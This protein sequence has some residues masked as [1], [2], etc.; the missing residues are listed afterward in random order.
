M[1]RR[2]RLKK[3]NIFH[4]RFIPNSFK[5]II[6]VWEELASARNKAIK[7]V[8]RLPTKTAEARSI[9]VYK[10]EETGRTV[11]PSQTPHAQPCQSCFSVCLSH[12]PALPQLPPDVLADAEVP[13]A[14]LQNRYRPVQLSVTL[15]I[16]GWLNT[17]C[18]KALKDLLNFILTTTGSIFTCKTNLLIQQI[19]AQL[20]KHWTHSK[21]A[22]CEW[23]S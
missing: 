12:L 23:F 3:R 22:V 9:A 21:M 14:H 2:Q 10:Q 19:K 17:L 8:H 18:L 15:M 16:W 6:S 4:A 5:N 20:A 7:L 1:V 13:A 11:V